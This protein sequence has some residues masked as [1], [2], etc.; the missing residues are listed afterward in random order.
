MSVHSMRVGRP[1]GCPLPQ[2]I[3]AF[4]MVT[5]C[6][7]D[8]QSLIFDEALAIQTLTKSRRRHFFVNRL[9]VAFE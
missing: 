2:H 3:Q 9:W 6:S 8:L 1:D 4:P 5:T 7:C